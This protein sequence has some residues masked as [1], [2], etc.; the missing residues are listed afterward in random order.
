MRVLVTGANG[1]IGRWTLDPLRNRG[2]EVHAVTTRSGGLDADVEWHQADLLRQSDRIALLEQTKPTHLL[3]LAWYTAHDLYWTSPENLKW[4]SSSIELAEEFASVGGERMVVAGTCA[5]YDW[6]YGICHE[7]RTPMAPNSFYG[8]CKSGLFRVLE[9]LMTIRGVSWG[10]PRIFHLYGPD[11]HPN[12]LVASVL[13]SLLS[14]QTV[15]C[16]HGRQ[17]R[18][19]LYVKDCAEALVEILCSTVEGPINVGSGD[20]MTI[21]ELVMTIAQE[22]DPTARLRFAEDRETPTSAAIVV[23]DTTR[24]RDEVG[25]KP[26]RS[27]GLGLSETAEWWSR[28]SDQL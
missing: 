6:S 14:Q 13:R 7:Y 18:D 15:Q 25:W 12:R 23:P 4:V 24:L 8:S 19:Y 11:E 16:S 21:R 9:G 3:H 20:P 5:E 10:W 2:A 27:L 17:V 22:I 26:L 28:V 1:F